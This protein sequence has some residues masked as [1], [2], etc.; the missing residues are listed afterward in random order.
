MKAFALNSKLATT[1]KYRAGYKSNPGIVAD[2]FDGSHYSNLCKAYVKVNDKVFNHTY[3]S[4]P[5]DVALGLSS[6]GFAPFNKRK[7]TAWPIIIFNYNLPPEIRFLVDNIL[8]LGVIPGPKKPQD[9]D[10]FLW[11]FIQELLRLAQG[12]HAFD[13]LTNS[14]FLLRAFLILVFG[15]IP[16][17]SM[18]MRM[19]GHNGFSPCRMCEIKGL[20]VPGVRATTHYVPLNQS[21]HPDV[22]QDQNHTQKYDPRNLPLR[23]HT[24]F[25]VQAAEVDAATTNA[26][27]SNLAKTYGIKGRP[28]LSV[29]HSLSF[30]CSFPYDFMHLIWENLIKNLV[31]LWTGEFKGLDEGNEVYELDKT[32][33]EAIGEG[34]TASG[35]TIPSAYGARVPNVAQDKSGCTADMWSFWTLYLGPILLRNR[36]RKSTYYKHFVKLVTLL[37]ICLQF[38]ITNEEIEMVREG[39]IKW[40]QEYEE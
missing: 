8:S 16:A 39:F 30:P 32:V 11:P 9:C 34:T 19:K 2:I 1:M 38:E 29:L 3:F 31:L 17:V 24:A 18:L 12:V 5:R 25:L 13:V 6:D 37:N 20:R 15:D 14:L 7:S 22:Q 4:D 33:W 23:T 35:S 26:S 40:V 10:S 28:L 21:P 27:A 36:F